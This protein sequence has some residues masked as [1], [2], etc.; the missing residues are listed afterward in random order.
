MHLT[1]R[2]SQ[3][4]KRPDDVQAVAEG[5]LL[6]KN[7]EEVTTTNYTM[8]ENGDSVE[9]TFNEVS[10]D[11]CFLTTSEYALYLAEKNKANLDYLSMELEVEL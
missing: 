2:R 8:D 9:E 6:H 4:F 11:E 10:Y 5:V 7:Y 1:W 3:S